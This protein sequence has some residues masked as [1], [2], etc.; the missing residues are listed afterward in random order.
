LKVAGGL[1]QSEALRLQVS[2]FL[3]ML[4]RPRAPSDPPLTYVFEV[5]LQKQPSEAV[6]KW[7]VMLRDCDFF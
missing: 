4:F 2:S 1:A 3:L 5:Q 7:A 6:K